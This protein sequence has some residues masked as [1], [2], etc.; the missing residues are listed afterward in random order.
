MRFFFPHFPKK[1]TFRLFPPH[2]SSWWLLRQPGCHCVRA[3]CLSL[4]TRQLALSP[5]TFPSALGAWRIKG[6][7]VMIEFRLFCTSKINYAHVKTAETPFIYIKWE[8]SSFTPNFLC[9]SFIFCTERELI[10][11]LIYS[12]KAEGLVW[13]SVKEAKFLQ[14]TKR[15]KVG[16]I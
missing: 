14:E 5:H 12:L 16:F 15:H 6:V 4:R 10:L 11:K 7:K 2:G 1:L 9:S 3:Q 13:K 8:L